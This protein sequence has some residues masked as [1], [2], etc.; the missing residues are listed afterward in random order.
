MVGQG[1]RSH[2]RRRV[3]AAVELPEGSR[4]HGEERRHREDRADHGV[5]AKRLC[6]EAP[7]TRARD[8]RSEEREAVLQRAGCP[9]Q[10]IAEIMSA[11]ETGC[12]TIAQG[13]ESPCL[14][15]DF[16]IWHRLLFGFHVHTVLTA[17]STR[18]LRLFLGLAQMPGARAPIWAVRVS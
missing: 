10:R 7:R 18:A 9:S 3:D 1:G 16:Q 8:G 11:H 4:S 2:V 6:A 17:A 5:E 12:R 13:R 15:A 14:G